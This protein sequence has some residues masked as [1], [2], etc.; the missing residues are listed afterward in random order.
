MLEE[1][2][3][4]STKVTTPSSSM[5]NVSPLGSSSVVGSSSIISKETLRALSLLCKDNSRNT[6]FIV[7]GQE[8]R[9]ISRVFDS[10]KDLGIAAEY[11]FMTRWCGN[12]EWRT[13][14]GHFT[15][16]W[17]PVVKEIMQLYTERTA[18]SYIEEKD[19]AILWRYDDADVDFGHLQASEMRDHLCVVLANNVC[20]V[21][22]GKGY[23][24]VRPS[25]IDKGAVVTRILDWAQGVTPQWQLKQQGLPPVAAGDG[26]LCA[27]HW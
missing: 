8:H 25:G 7:S 19:S 4:S 10:V 22:H 24:E 21:L 27:M 17:K 26:R 14:A 18:A 23:V 12:S 2:S 15:D 11:G 20:D 16:D 9:L 3:C 5:A 13:L 6:V 1:L